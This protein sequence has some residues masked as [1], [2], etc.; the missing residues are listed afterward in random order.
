M[1]LEFSTKA[2]DLTQTLSS[3][4]KAVEHK[5]LAQDDELRQIKQ[6]KDGYAE[7]WAALQ[8]AYGNLCSQVTDLVNSAHSGRLE[9]TKLD[10]GRLEWTSP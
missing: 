9:S 2:A 5:M 4:M 3:F 10:F 8:R 7:T 6:I 1:Q